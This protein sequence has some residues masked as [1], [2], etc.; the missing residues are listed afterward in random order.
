MFRLYNTLTKELEVV[1]PLQPGSVGMYTCGPTVYRDAH[2]GNLRSYLM[3][4]WIRR[5][6][7]A[8][9]VEVTH[10][11]N[12]TDVG[13]MR[14]EMLERGEDKVIAAA[15]REGKTPAQIASFYTERF[16]EDEGKLKI[17]PAHQFPKATDHIPEMLDV[18][19]RL[20]EKGYAYEV[21]GNVYFEVSKFHE[22]GKLSGNIHEAELLEAVRVELDPLKR[23]PRD[24]TLWKQAEPGRGVKWPCPWGEGFPGWH[25]ECSAMSIKYLG[26]RFDIHTGGVDNI[27]PHHEDEIAQSEALTG[28]PVVNLWVHGQHLL[29]DGVK[30]AKSTGNSFTMSDIEGQGIDPLAFRYLC[31]TARYGTRLNFTFT[32]LKA[33]Q[34]GLLRLRNRVWRCSLLPPEPSVDGRLVEKWWSRFME[35]VGD[36]LDLPGAL[37]LTWQLM[38]SPLDGRVKVRIVYE[39]DRV[40]GLGLDSVPE[41]YQVSS[42]VRELIEQRSGLRRQ[43]NYGEA[44]ALRDKL[45]DAGYVVE[46]T[47]DGTR[48]RPKTPWEKREERWHSFSS[49]AELP[50]LV[51]EAHGPDVTVAIVASNFLEDVKRCVHS[52][53]RWIEDRRAEVVLVDNCSTDGTGEWLA[54]AAARDSRIRVIHTDHVLGEGAAKN[55]ALKQSRGRTIVIIDTSVEI[56]GDIFGPIEEMLAND[57]VGVAGPFGLRSDNLHHFH[58]G[59]GEAGDMDA[60]QAY[61]FAFRRERLKDVGL[62]RESFRF[63]RNLDLDYSLHFKDK[64]YRIVAEPSLPLRRGEH[65]AWSGLG[66]EE[67][68]E[69]SRKNF[70]RFLDRWGDRE[71]LLVANQRRL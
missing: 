8:Q 15:I 55:I 29:A 37:A 19:Q 14:Q 31:L 22:Y 5:A 11:K 65:R 40:L 68:D 67:R 46:D 41:A 60:M 38:K 39:L 21:N 3:A 44:D 53:L 42:D 33:A 47:P 50:S 16:L 10:V 51:H 12:I 59:E 70:G 30:M 2:I 52:A 4:D 57:T 62:M 71:D 54:E 9:G 45:A 56:T 7:E 32:A 18:V 1:K 36:N 43:G 61:C 23:D 6:L 24:F 48:V 34:R 26:R 58:D 69:L 17:S 28:E 64:G 27:F 66:E 35:R 25:I 49:S 13:H 20:V 63:Y